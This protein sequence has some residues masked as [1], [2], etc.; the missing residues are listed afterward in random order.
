MWSKLFFSILVI[1]TKYIIHNQN[2]PSYVFTAAPFELLKLI[3][4]RL[5]QI[6]IFHFLKEKNKQSI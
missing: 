6:I 1:Q 3:E 4:E 5:L 2:M